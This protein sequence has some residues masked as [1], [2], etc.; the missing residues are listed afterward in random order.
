VVLLVRVIYS[1]TGAA[2]VRRIQDPRQA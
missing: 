1:H 2:D